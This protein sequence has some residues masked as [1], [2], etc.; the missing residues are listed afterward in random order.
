M[1]LGSAIVSKGQLKIWLN[2]VFTRKSIDVASPLKVAKPLP[3][4][5]NEYYTNIDIIFVKNCIRSYIDE[6]L[7]DSLRGFILRLLK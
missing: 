4:I 6:G 7:F 5:M 2:I 1:I 3:I